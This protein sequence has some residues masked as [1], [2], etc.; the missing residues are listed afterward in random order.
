MNTVI[1]TA[2]GERQKLALRLLFAR[3]PAEEQETRLGDAIAASERGTLQL[4]NLLL[5]ETDGLPVGAALVMLQSDGIALVWPPVVSCGAT[6]SDAVED[7]LM[8]GVC[9][10]ID[11]ASAKLG[12]CLLAPDDD[13]EVA[14][15]TRHG[16][17][18]ATDMFF[19]A[20]AIT[21]TAAAQDA[22]RTGN[23]NSVSVET[24][25]PRNADRFARLIEETYRGSLDCPYLNGIRTGDEAI[26]SH[27]LSGEFDPDRW[28]IYTVSGED[29]GVL[30]LNDHPD[31][32]AVELVYVGVAPKSRG[33][34]LGRQMIRE[35]LNK[36]AHRGRAVM[37]LAVD[38]ENHFANSLYSEFEFA[39]LARRRVMLRRSFGL[40][41]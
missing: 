8:Q 16:F 10:R 4:E 14:V 36:S 20:R 9:H 35:G 11:T 6:D 30:L 17:E 33:R 5:A 38:C 23:A 27:K 34:G 32:D 13:A 37:F 15:L 25:D 18:R 12:Q 29:A 40:A 26:A 28:A 2:S 21:S 39:E 22:D 41:R 19:L 1:N 7:L 31:Q 3:F 24:Y